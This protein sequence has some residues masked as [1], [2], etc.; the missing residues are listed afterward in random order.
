MTE[1]REVPARGPEPDEEVVRE[2]VTLLRGGGILVHPTG[3]LYGLGAATAAGDREIARLKG[4]DPGRP[5]LRIAASLASLRAAHP[6]AVWD[7]RAARL[8]GCFWPG[9][10]TLVLEDGS[11]DGLA[12]RVVDHAVTRAVL[13][14]LGSTI[15]S[16][17]VNRAGESPARSPR[18]VREAVAGM[19]GGGSAVLFLNAGAT[20]SGRPS[21][22]VS[23]REDPPR[24]LREGAVAREEIEESL[25]SRP[26]ETR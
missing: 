4:R 20:S 16:T 24:L 10:V 7:E 6:E 11:P 9:S 21:T 1:I 14:E 26:R 13:E 17:S 23:L 22:I 5:L 8:A 3:T 18:E 19:A 15:S 2:A 25:G 12:V